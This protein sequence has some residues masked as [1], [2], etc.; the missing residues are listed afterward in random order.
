[1][2]VSN[3]DESSSPNSIKLYQNYPNPFNPSTTISFELD[4]S[5]KITLEVFNMAGQL[6]E[7]VTNR[8]Y[9]V[10][11]HSLKFQADNLASGVYFYRLKTTNSTQTKKFTL[12]K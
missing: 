1:M 2:I 4:N 8:I 11:N 10:G 12:I 6:V 3:E 9:G 5:Q 7:T